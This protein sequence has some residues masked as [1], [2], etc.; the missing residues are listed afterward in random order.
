MSFHFR[1]SSHEEAYLIVE[2]L[3][4]A[5]FVCSS[6]FIFPSTLLGAMAGLEVE[7][8]GS[9]GILGLCEAMDDPGASR[10]HGRWMCRDGEN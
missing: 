6:L 5:W 3:Q 9:H 10:P 2:G 7:V 1:R 8:L 4:V